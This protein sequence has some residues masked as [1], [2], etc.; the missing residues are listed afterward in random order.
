MIY[1]SGF[2]IGFLKQCTSHVCAIEMKKELGIPCVRI[3]RSSNCC[4]A[5]LS[6]HETDLKLRL[7]N[8]DHVFVKP[9]SP[10]KFINIYL[11]LTISM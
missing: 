8:A 10:S 9:F 2:V 4:Y 6:L 3:K 11:L 1:S 5:C 7:V